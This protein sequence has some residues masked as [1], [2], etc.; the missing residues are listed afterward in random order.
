MDT[1]RGRSENLGS[2]SDCVKRF[3]LDLAFAKVG[4]VGVLP[5]P[6]SFLKLLASLRDSI[7]SA[8]PQVLDSV[9]GI[10]EANF[11]LYLQF[12]DG[13]RSAGHSLFGSAHYDFASLLAGSGGEKEP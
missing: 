5:H 2:A 3:E 10:R 7:F 12:F 9:P 8:L 11:D 13:V 4:A 1:I 6:H